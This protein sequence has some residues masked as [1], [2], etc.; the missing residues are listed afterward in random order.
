MEGIPVL[1]AGDADTTE[2]AVETVV[3]GER[4]PDGAVHYLEV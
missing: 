4:E 3:C 2:Q 1:L